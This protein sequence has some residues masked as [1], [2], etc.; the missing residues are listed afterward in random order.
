VE[1]L[2]NLVL[3]VRII[4]EHPVFGIG[5]GHYGVFWGQTVHGDPHYWPGYTP[6][7][8]FLKVFAETGVVGFLLL[9]LLLGFLA[10]L[11]VRG[12]RA[13]PAQ[14]RSRYLALLFG[15]LA[16]LLNMAIGYELLHAFFWINV[17]TLLYLVDRH[18]WTSRW[19]GSSS[20]GHASRELR[21]ATPS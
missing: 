13:I 6:N 4:R 3:L 10:R 9:L 2:E 7:M 15:A 21:P 5:P 12:Y 16:I 18:R 1:R 8:D 19:S 14:E 17:G 20:W 11:F